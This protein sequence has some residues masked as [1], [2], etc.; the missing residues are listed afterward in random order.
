V[1]GWHDPAMSRSPNRRGAAGRPNAAVRAEPRGIGS[2]GARDPLALE[3]RLLGA[4]LGQVLA[5][6]AGPE[7]LET[8]ERIRRLTIALRR[9]VPETGSGSNGPP[10][11]APDAPD[12]AAEVAERARLDAELG[13]LTADRAALVARAFTGY[14]RLVNLAESRHRVRVLARRERASRRPAPD[15]L[16]GT[17]GSILADG[18]LRPA[19]LLELVGRLRLSPVFTAHPTEARRRTILIA[20]GR[21]ARLVERLDDPRLA[22]EADRELRRGLREEIAVLWRTEEFRS[23][24]PTPLDE[25]RTAMAIFDETIYRVVPRVYRGLDGA[26][27]VLDRDAARSGSAAPSGASGPAEPAADSRR[28]GT[29]P[30]IAPA[31]LRFGTWIGADRD[32]HPAVTADV[33]LRAARIAADHV[34]HGHEA[35]A[36]RLMQSIAA[37]PG[38]DGLTR[39]LETRLGR[40]AEA[41]PDLDRHLRGR[42]PGEAYRRRLGFVAERLRRT[43]SHL[44]GVPG[45]VA[46]RYGSPDELVAELGELQ[47]ALVAGG[48]PR[49]AWGEVAEFRWQVETFGFHL[50]SLEVRQHAAVHRAALD[51]LEAAGGAALSG[52]AA[53]PGATVLAR[54][55][56]PGVSVGEVLATFRAIRELQDRFGEAAAHRVVVSFTTE[57][58]DA[59][60]VLELAA[61]AVPDRPPALDVVPLLESPEALEGAAE[62]IDGLL[63]RPAY[64]AHVARRGHRQEVMLGYSDSNKALG[65]VTANWLLHRAQGAL[66][67]VAAQHGV[68]LTLFHGRGGAIGRGG[69]PTQRA[70]L[71]Q[72]PGSIDGRFKLTEQ[73]EVIA[74]NYADPGIARRHLELVSGAVLRASTPAHRASLEAG[75][76]RGATLMDE[77]ASTA[78]RAYRDLVDDPGFGAFFAAMTPIGAIAGLP[79]GSRPAA[80]ARGGTGSEPALRVDDLRAI[81]WTFAWSQVRLDL[82]GWYGLGSALEAFRAAHGEAGLD[83][84]GRLHATWPFLASLLDNAALALAR[85]DVAVA[86]RYAALADAPGDAE[87]WAAIEA[88]HGRSSG[89][90]LRVTGR[91]HLLEDRPAV[92][93]AIELRNPY[94]DPLSE[95]QVR[96][97]AGLGTLGPDDPERPGWEQVLGLTV[98]GIA[99]GLQGTG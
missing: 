98:S 38:S 54:E 80:R 46:G 18:L 42:F 8:V 44:A 73:G 68:E 10:G 20:L 27:D 94:V 13:R 72:A 5:E 28:T 37:T 56:A 3:V 59:V 36:T 43:R 81:P 55:A 99:A 93:R 79:Y 58:D 90:L 11:G 91:R 53:P 70:V 26:L 65:Y 33:T 6:Q 63:G 74:A 51:A 92:W 86:R 83:E 32:G 62:L 88:E 24:A 4:L 89:L 19:D 78:R 48:L 31:F 2:A 57:P 41:F 69:G 25:V 39:A 96:A 85:A 64:R 30:P 21:I 16:P 77:L 60:A 84:L 40:D 66:V 61:R 22:P 9:A 87:R 1:A 76:A 71:G 35:V 45:P 97:L 15:S 23:I 47:A 7:L 17:V 82:P 50:A 49:T 75:L 12:V 29:R 52:A 14:F 95:L 67:E 34:L